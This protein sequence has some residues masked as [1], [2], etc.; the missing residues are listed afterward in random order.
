MSKSQNK[1]IDFSTL[2]QAVHDLNNIFTSSINSIDILEKSIPKENETTKLI[3]TI[4]TNSL[5]AVDIINN[6]LTNKSKQ[7]NNISIYDLVADIKLTTKE[8]LPKNI[9]L[10]FRF[11][12]N[13]NRVYAN[14]TDLYRVLL[15]LI[16]N[17]NES[18]NGKG[19]IIFSAKNSR[20]KD[21]VVI[22]IKD[23]GI[24]ITNKTLK[25]IFDEG[26]STKSKTT[27]SGI[28]LA[29][30]KSII[31]EHNG[32]IEVISKYRS[33]TEFIISLP[34]TRKTEKQKSKDKFQTIL[35]ADDDQVILELFSELLISYDYKVVSAKDGKDAID[36]FNKNKFDIVIADK[37]MP[38]IDGLEL[39]KIIRKKDS[40][41]PI[42]LTT[43]SQEAIDEQYPNLI[44]NQKIKKPWSFEDM[45]DCIQTLLR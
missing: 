21:Y 34:T 22:S 40:K 24:G 30:V 27:N 42:I 36:K 11:G 15:N 9:K 13:L 35:L 17:A 14:Y 16:I 31:E 39:I 20:K 44:I 23:N 1:S 25:N 43:G 41:I 32:N 8:T 45:L 6:L 10:Q 37:I 4:R 38:K 2:N 33:G 28:G 12:K 26:Y 29:I 7:K 19:T 5:R 18:I 3:S